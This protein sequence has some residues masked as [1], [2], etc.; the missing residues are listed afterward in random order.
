M[1][2]TGLLATADRAILGLLGGVVRYSPT[3][4]PAVTIKGIFDCAYLKVA[5]GQ[6]GISSEG[7][8]VWFRES[9]LPSDPEV[10]L[11]AE[12]TIGETVFTIRETHKDGQGGVLI[13]LHE[14]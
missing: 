10:D 13:F 1:S 4:G 5:L 11:E 3:T 6:A 12:I 14:A 7:P 2:F 8:V 9:D